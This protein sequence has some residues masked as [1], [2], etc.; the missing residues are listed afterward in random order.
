MLVARRLYNC[1]FGEQRKAVGMLV[2]VALG[3]N[4]LLKRG[5]IPSEENQR[6]NVQVAARALAPLGLEH[7]LVITHGNGPQVGM[8]ALESTCVPGRESYALDV[9]GAESSGM[10]GYMVEQEL[11]NVLPE[12]QPFATILTQVEVDAAD[13]AF[14]AP[15][16][17]IGPMYGKKEAEGLA[18]ER[19]WSIGPD[20]KGWRRL[21][22]SPRPKRIFELRV[23]QLLVEHDVI[24]ICA[25]GGGIPTILR[26]DGILIGA[27]AVVDK[28]LAGELLARSLLADAYLMLTD[29]DAVYHSWGTPEARAIRCASPE[30][31]A[32]LDFPAG[33]MGPK[34]EAACRFVRETG[35]VAAIGSLANA[36]ALLAGD[37]GT[38]VTVGADG[39]EWYEAGASGMAGASGPR[40]PS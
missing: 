8:L 33:S 3:G 11:G 34:V 37:V 7:R 5:E 2:V 12:D 24:V 22:P 26:E 6:R 17:P 1:S 28:D 27:E 30:A 18:A 21:V 19:G 40:S 39:I 38:R 23:I 13:P 16:K 29:V 14:Q 10:I 35:R 15:T 36:A 32:A 4:A 20:G 9:L 25:G 31:L